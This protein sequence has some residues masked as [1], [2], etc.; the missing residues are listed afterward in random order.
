MF[1][2]GNHNDGTAGDNIWG[3]DIGPFNYYDIIN[4]LFTVTDNNS[5][6][7]TFQGST[8]TFPP[9]LLKIT[10]FLSDHCIIGIH[11]E[12]LK[13]KRVFYQHNSMVCNGMQLLPTKI[14][15]HPKVFGSGPQILQIRMDLF[16]RTKLFTQV[17]E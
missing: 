17:Q 7:I 4:T 1:D 3:L 10:G 9:P 11:Q 12:V 2:D 8:I 14:F 5:Q 6:S 13:L 15:R 16:I